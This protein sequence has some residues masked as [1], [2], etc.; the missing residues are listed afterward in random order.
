MPLPL[1]ALGG[2]VTGLVGAIGQASQRKKSNAQLEKL[3]GQDPS[4]TANPIAAKRAA[5]AKS[6]LFARMPGAASVER[7]I[8]GNTANQVG[9]IQ[10]NAT[11][12]SQAIAAASG[13]FAQGDQA[14]NQ[15]GI[16]EAQDFQRRYGNYDAAQEGVIREGDKVYNDQ[17]RRFGDLVNIRG[18]QQE[19]KSNL[20]KD[21]SN[22]G[23]GLTNFGLAGGFQGMFGETNRSVMGGLQ[24]NGTMRG[25]SGATTNLPNFGGNMNYSSPSF[26]RPSLPNR[27]PGLY[28]YLNRP[29]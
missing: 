2:L 22:F 25:G 1:L 10:K 12:A 27:I 19:N 13:A 16:N 4:Y 11:D 21:I 7:N 26:N 14:F 17:V 24:S 28:N 18:A 6:L 23:T 3:I 15:L 5:L 8:Y 20:W 9:N 29:R